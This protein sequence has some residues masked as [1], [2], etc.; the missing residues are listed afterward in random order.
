M[1]KKDF[2]K[3]I[4]IG[5]A[6]L[7]FLYAGA[8][9]G[10]AN[11]KI[12]DKDLILQTASNTNNQPGGSGNSALL[13]ETIPDGKKFR[14]IQDLYWKKFGQDTLWFNPVC[15]LENLKKRNKEKGRMPNFW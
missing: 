3:K 1:E 11:S 14:K 8:A 5:I 9:E 4:A 2:C 10:E 6:L 7:I 15:F 13:K 12:P